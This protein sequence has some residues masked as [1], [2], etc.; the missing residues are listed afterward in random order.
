MKKIYILG[1]VLA[2]AFVNAQ[3]FNFNTNADTEGMAGV[4]AGVTVTQTTVETRGVVQL[5]HAGKSQPSFSLTNTI[6]ASTNKE[7]VIVFQNNSNANQFRIKNTGSTWVGAVGNITSSSTAWQSLTLDLTTL[8]GYSA[9]GT[10]TLTLQFRNGSTA[11]AG[12]IYVDSMIIKPITTL[13]TTDFNSTTATIYPNPAKDVLNINT[14]ETV[15]KAE[16][17]TILGET[18][19]TV[20]NAGNTINVS[21]LNKGIYF[22]K[23]TSSNGVST[24]KFIK[25]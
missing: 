10:Y 23:V 14:Q 17:L 3:T 24:T 25:E 11:L 20:N 18:V 6:N 22:L 1:L 19:L 4:T 21:A 8:E 16:V 12:N 15:Q 2:T 13:N 9:D 5:D 7:L